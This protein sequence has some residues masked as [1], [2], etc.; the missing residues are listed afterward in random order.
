MSHYLFQY[1]QT[2]RERRWLLLAPEGKY[3]SQTR[4]GQVPMH[5]EKETRVFLVWH[6]QLIRVEARKE[7]IYENGPDRLRGRVWRRSYRTCCG[8]DGKGGYSV[9]YL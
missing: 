4:K 8:G 2:G 1:P 6:P 9:H 5:E 7:R 3:T